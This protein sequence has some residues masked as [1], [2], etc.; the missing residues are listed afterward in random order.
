MHSGVSAKTGW[1]GALWIGVKIIC[2][3]G[4]NGLL[5]DCYLSE[6]SYLLTSSVQDER[7]FQ[8]RVV[9]TKLNI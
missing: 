3:S 2:S 4:V 1:L 8:K 5:L 6:L 7:L 9:R